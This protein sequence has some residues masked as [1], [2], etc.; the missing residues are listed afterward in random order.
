MDIHGS[1]TVVTGGTG[2]LGSRIAAAFAREGAKVAVV[3]QSSI[4]AAHDLASRLSSETGA[5]VAA[6][7]ADQTDPAAVERLRDEVLA[8]FGGIDVLVNNAAVNEWIPFP[9]L[10]ALTPELW[11]HILRTNVTGPFLCARAF[12]PALRAGGRGRIVNISSIAGFDAQGSS[13][14]YASSKAALNHLTRCLAVA[15][16]PDVLVNGVAP[17]YMEGTRMSTKLPPE[18]VAFGIS[19]SLLRR[20]TSREDVADQ[21]V[22]FV[23]SDSTTGQTVC[24]DAGRYLH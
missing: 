21:V 6:F 23:R 12:A 15:L 8:T 3:C 13:I 2:G 18:R 9:D 5:Q 24:V 20:P 11:D 14:A 17:G 22:A 7:A 19:S 10:D 16:A 4:D 1:V